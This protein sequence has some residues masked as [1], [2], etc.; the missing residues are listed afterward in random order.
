MPRQARLV[1]PHVPHHITQRGNQGQDV[2]RSDEDREVYLG[3]L[4]EYSLEHGLAIWAYCLMSNHVHIV[5]VPASR[6]GL[7]QVLRSVQMRH[8]Q[9]MNERHSLKGHLWHSRYFSCPLD[10]SHLWEAVRYVECNPVRAG[11]VE[12]AERYSWSSAAGHCGLRTDPL[13]APDLPLLKTIADWSRWLA[14]APEGEATQR[15]RECTH[16]GMPCGSKAFVARVRSGP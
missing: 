13:L 2:F 8:A 14:Q 12:Q 4:R 3:L 16:S 5:A 1:I 7:P 6:D 15:L 9:R 11:L 10:S